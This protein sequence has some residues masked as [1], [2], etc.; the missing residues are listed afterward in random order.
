MGVPYYN[1]S[2]ICPTALILILLIDPFSE[3]FKGPLLLII[4]APKS[5]VGGSQRAQLGKKICLGL[6]CNR[7]DLP[8]LEPF[9]I[10]VPFLEPFFIFVPFLEAFF[11]IVP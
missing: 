4:K 3:A 2:R 6:T 8:F 1:H 5:A 9:F 7:K 10:V 11:I